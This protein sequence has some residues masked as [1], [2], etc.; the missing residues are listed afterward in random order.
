MRDFISG[1]GKDPQ[2][3]PSTHKSLLPLPLSALKKMNN[4]L[5][6]LL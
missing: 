4:Q 1:D 3:Q 2:S 6:L 5:Q